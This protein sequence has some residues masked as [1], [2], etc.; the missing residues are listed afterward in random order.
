MTDNRN[1]SD[2]WNAAGR[3]AAL[4]LAVVLFAGIWESDSGPLPSE[5]RGRI[6]T[7]LP[8]A[9]NPVWK[10]SEPLSALAVEPQSDIVRLD[11]TLS[12]HCGLVRVQVNLQPLAAGAPGLPTLNSQHVF[13]GN[14]EELKSHLLA[15]LDKLDSRSQVVPVSAQ[16]ESS[17]AEPVAA[18]TGVSAGRGFIFLSRRPRYRTTA[19]SRS[20][21]LRPGL[22]D[23][24]ATGSLL[25]VE[26][27]STPR[28]LQSRL[29]DGALN[30]LPNSAE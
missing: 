29:I 4:C 22:E 8:A 21:G 30:L 26:L 24:A 6:E 28:K 11:Q 7:A 16:V 17:R 12:R 2:S 5:E 3:V 10:S 18:E 14:I 9:P 1:Q 23:S 15:F 25:E 20:P 27:Q 19:D 13:R